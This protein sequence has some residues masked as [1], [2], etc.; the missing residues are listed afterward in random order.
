M[1]K[2]ISQTDLV[3]EFFINNPNRNIEHPEVVDWVVAKW[4]NRT[5]EVFRDP[6]TEQFVLYLKKVF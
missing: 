4:K 1:D 5:G 6:P 3:R 2:K